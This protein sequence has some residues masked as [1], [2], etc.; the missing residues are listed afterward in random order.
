LNLTKLRVMGFPLFGSFVDQKGEVQFVTMKRGNQAALEIETLPK[1]VWGKTANKGKRGIT[2][3]E[4][5]SFKKIA[6]N[7][8][9]G[10]GREWKI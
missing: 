6:P 1:Y 7:W 3:F 4:R 2:N 10:R 5:G 9:Q 8:N